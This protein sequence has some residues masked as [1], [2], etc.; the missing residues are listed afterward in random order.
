MLTHEGITRPITEWALDYGIYPSVITDRLARGWTT[1]RAITTPMVVAPRQRLSCSHMP[2]MEQYSRV[3]RQ[4]RPRGPSRT[5][6]G[7]RL[8]HNGRCLSIREWSELLG[9]GTATI[10][11][12]IREGWPLE[13]VLGPLQQ[14][15]RKPGVVLNFDPSKGTGGGSVAQEIS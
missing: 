14:G 11:R 2:G 9:I 8:T 3:P 13:R 12:R 4:G 6:Q 5:R 1:G 10:D 15:G 7:K